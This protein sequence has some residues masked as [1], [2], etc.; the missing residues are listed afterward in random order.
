MSMPAAS[1]DSLVDVPLFDLPDGA[2]TGVRMDELSAGGRRRVRQAQAVAAGVHPLR[3]VG[4]A[5]TMH[6]DADRNASS[7]D[8]P[9]LPLRCGTCAHRGENMYH[10]PKCR[11]GGSTRVTNGDGT[12][13]RAWWPACTD[14]SLGSR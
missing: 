9:N 3:L 14:Y 11:F 8:G 6:P 12:T 1:D 10:F 5:V 4:I 7:A 13:V 2:E